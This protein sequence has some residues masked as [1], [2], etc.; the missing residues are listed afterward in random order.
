LRVTL[1]GAALDVEPGI[2]VEALAQRLGVRLVPGCA[3]AVKRS[4]PPEK[5]ETNLYG[6][7]TSK[8]RMVVRIECEK[9]MEGWRRVFGRF[10]GSGIR[11]VTR[12]AAVFGPVV[13]DFEPSREGVELRQ[14]EIALSL[15]GFSNETTHLVFGKRLHSS[16]YAPPK[17]CGVV[18]KVVYGRHVVEELRMGDH[19]EKIEPVVE[20]REGSG[21]VQRGEPKQEL[22]EPVEI[23]TRIALDLEQGSPMSGEVVYKVTAGGTL[24]VFRKTSRYVACDDLGLVALK[25][26]RQYRRGRGSITVRNG[27]SMVGSV[28]LY[29]REAALAPSHNLTGAVERGMELADILAEGDRVAVEVRPERMELLGGKMADAERILSGKAIAMK[30]V[31]D[32]SD[33]ALVVDQEPPTTLE[34]YGRKEVSCTGVDPSR[35]LRVRLF[36]DEAPVTVKYFRRVTGLEMRRVGRLD[37]FF[38]TPKNE[39]VLFKGDEVLAKVLLPENT[40]GKKVGVNF[41]GVTNTIKRFTGMVGVRFTESEEF[42]PTAEKFDGT[43]IVGEVVGNVGTIKGLKGKESI[44]MMEETP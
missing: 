16:A 34:V 21:T 22:K 13:S 14:Y 24:K 32:A 11:W 38:T 35:V 20:F 9:I 15:A 28:Y 44:Y 7:T 17:G 18:G 3:L 33:G 31:G 12:E 1:D 43:N 27:G 36:Q 5:V 29:L 23:F 10:N 30:R 8:G 42:G 25:A 39:I 19:V 4:V 41:I 2:T 26:E 37:V 6:I 40:P